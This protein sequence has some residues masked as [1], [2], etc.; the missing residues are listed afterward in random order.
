MTSLL[1]YSFESSVTPTTGVLTTPKPLLPGD[2]RQAPLPR[3]Q[4]K[5]PA[6]DVVLVLGLVVLL[7]LF[8]VLLVLVQV[9]V[10]VVVVVVVV[11]VALVAVLVVACI[12]LSAAVVFLWRRQLA[13]VCVVVRLV[14]PVVVRIEVEVAVEAAVEVLFA[15]LTLVLHQ[16]LVIPW[17]LRATTFSCPRAASV[18]RLYLA[19]WHRLVGQRYLPPP[20]SRH[21]LRP[22]V[23][24]CIDVDCRRRRLLLNDS[25]TRWSQRG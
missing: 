20:L 18:H 11:V 13:P 3:S 1:I 7:L 21:H 17:L 15:I 9:L 4:T 5:L 19:V 23:V 25:L 22:S 6:F 24:L 8:K 12:C 10:L 2:G 14:V 16:V